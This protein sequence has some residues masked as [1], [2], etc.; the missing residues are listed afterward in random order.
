MHDVVL[1]YPKTGFDLKKTTDMPLSLLTVASVIKDD[2]N[3]KIIDQRVENKWKRMLLAELE[4]T[5]LCV[6]ISSMTGSQIGYGLR[7]AEMIK[8][9]AAEN[10]TKTKVV[11]GGIHGTLLPE[12]TIENKNI[13]ILVT[14]E[15]EFTFRELVFTL[16][17]RGELSKIRGIYYKSDGRIIKTR[18]REVAD[19]NE[20]PEIAY[21]LVDIEAYVNSKS[22]ITDDVNRVLPFISSRGCPYQCT[23][24]CNP[25]LSRRRWRPLGADKTYERIK[26]MVDDYDLDGIVFYDENFLANP[27]RAMKI[28]CLINNKF[29]W[30]IQGRMDAISRINIKKL[31]KMGLRMVQPG[32][33]SGSDRILKLI[34]KGETKRDMELANQRL[35]KT[36][37]IPVY[38]F[39][40]G[41]PTETYEDI[42]DTV[43]FSLKLM[44]ENEK[45]EIAGFYILVPYPGTEVFDLAVKEG[46]VPPKSLEEWSKF[47]RQHNETP[48]VKNNQDLLNS[49]MLISKII[50]GKRIEKF[51]GVKPLRYPLKLFGYY[52]RGMWKR[53]RLE[54][55]LTKILAKSLLGMTKFVR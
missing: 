11:W 35:A 34:K 1:V 31:D 46:F 51:I 6:G 20:M 41:F 53:H 38:N 43:D 49:L 47:D 42:K 32:I 7:A 28:A 21:E 54:S 15:G 4:K 10:D 37:I 12:Q 24:C 5:P 48:W 16:A 45:A 40:V 52:Y 13:D 29:S 50:D 14:G 3:I 30:S 26:R 9:Y 23:F 8:D 22:M 39:M 19:I 36:D 44:D 2:F 25:K 55:R 17:R 27:D 18:E 33:E